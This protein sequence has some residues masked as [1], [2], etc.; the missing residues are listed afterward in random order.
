MDYLDL[1][2]CAVCVAPV[3]TVVLDDPTAPRSAPI[4]LCLRCDRSP[5]PEDVLFVPE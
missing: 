1:K 5:H 4:L 3:A 2:R